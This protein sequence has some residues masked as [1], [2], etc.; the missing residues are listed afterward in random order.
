MPKDRRDVDFFIPACELVKQEFQG[1]SYMASY[2]PRHVTIHQLKTCSGIFEHLI[3]E[4]VDQTEPRLSLKLI[5]GWTLGDDASL[6]HQKGMALRFEMS[7]SPE[8]TQGV[9][10]I[11][12]GSV[13]MPKWGYL[14]LWA[15]TADFGFTKLAEMSADEESRLKRSLRADMQRAFANFSEQGEGENG[16]GECGNIVWKSSIAPGESAGSI[17]Y[18]LQVSHIGQ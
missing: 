13:A 12:K 11:E 5:G 3:K 14:K 8:G 9:Q 16:S 4:S 2:N 7:E 10:W 18:N 6:H 1:T 17:T 15:H